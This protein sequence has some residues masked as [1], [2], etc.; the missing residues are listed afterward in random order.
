MPMTISHDSVHAQL[1]DG[2]RARMGDISQ[3]ELARRSGV[4]APAINRILSGKQQCSV[5][6][7]Q[8]LYDA[9][10]EASPTPPDAPK[11]APPP[12]EEPEPVPATPPAEVIPSEADARLAE[13]R[14]RITRTTAEAPARE[15][16]RAWFSAAELRGQ[17]P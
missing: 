10:G 8:K 5:A 1:L 4:S 7:W 12:Q 15:R 13:A 2:L 16:R 9:A 3:G 6:M 14:A 11:P 17:Q